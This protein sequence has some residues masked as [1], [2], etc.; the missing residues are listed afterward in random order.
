MLIDKYEV[1]SVKFKT[2]FKFKCTT[3]HNQFK[4]ADIEV[5]K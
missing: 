1:K 3:K 4:Y 5:K 2:E